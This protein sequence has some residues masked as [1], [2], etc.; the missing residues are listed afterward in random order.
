MTSVVNIADYRRKR[1]ARVTFNRGELRQL[2]DVYSRRVASGE[3][4]DYAIDLYPGAAVFSVF[5]N[6]F[7]HPLFAVA[8]RANGGQCD[9][10]LLSGR[11]KLRQGKTMQ[12]VL[13]VF[14]R[15]LRLIVGRG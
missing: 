11:R 8:K 3:W 4:R 12:E 14:D 1:R 10:L 6:T 9:Y 5:R 13:S 7:D 2:L 15:P